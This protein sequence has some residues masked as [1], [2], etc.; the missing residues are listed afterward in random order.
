MG[1]NISAILTIFW[2]VCVLV[3]VVVLINS[4]PE[5]MINWS[6]MYFG[7]A[8][9]CI[10]LFVLGLKANWKYLAKKKEE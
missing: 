9:Y 6:A 3:P 2:M 8:I 1:E 7:G 4:I 5:P 10:G